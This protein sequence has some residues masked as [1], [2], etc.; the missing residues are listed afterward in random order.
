MSGAKSFESIVY[1]SY[2]LFDSKQGPSAIPLKHIL[3]VFESKS[4]SAVGFDGFKLFCFQA[5]L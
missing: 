3:N 4:Y 1:L 2:H 5:Q